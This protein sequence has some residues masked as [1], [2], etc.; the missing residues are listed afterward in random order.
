MPPVVPGCTIRFF[1]K[2]RDV[3]VFEFIDDRIANL[4][5]R[6]QAL[7]PGGYLGRGCGINHRESI[8]RDR[9]L[10]KQAARTRYPPV[11]TRLH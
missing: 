1:A 5:Q 7:R 11:K 3:E 2:R 9:I 10:S 8:L 4:G 6:Q